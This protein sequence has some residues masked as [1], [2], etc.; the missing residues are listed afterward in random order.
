MRRCPPYPRPGVSLR[1]TPE[2]IR[3]KVSHFNTK[4]CLDFSGVAA[5]LRFRP[6]IPK[7][8]L[9]FFTFL[10]AFTSG[11]LRFGPVASCLVHRGAPG[12][13]PE[14][15]AGGR[16]AALGDPRLGPATRAEDGLGSV[17]PSMRV[18][19]LY[20]ADDIL[21]LHDFS[22]LNPV[23]YPFCFFPNA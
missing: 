14:H 11:H 15:R 21:R 10:E 18:F 9:S 1:R 16:G 20:F 22:F 23:C 8:S 2:I 19:K 13:C 5:F 4:R 6:L 17:R 3:I 7:E 12:L